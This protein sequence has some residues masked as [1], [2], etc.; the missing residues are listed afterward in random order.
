MAD[1]GVSQNAGV[2][3][4]GTGPFS[5]LARQQYAALAR[6]RW[7]SFV[8]GIRS[9]RGVL[10]LGA[11]GVA[12]TIYAS[13]GLGLGAAAGAAANVL[14]SRGAWQ[15][16]AIEFWVLCILWQAIS[17]ALASFQ[18]QY[19][20]SGLLRFPIS[21]SSFFLLHLIFGLL[22]VSTIIGGLCCLGILLGTA[23][24]RPDLL[25]WIAVVLAGFAAFNILLVRVI[26]AWIDRWLA[27]RRSREIVSAIFLLG[28]LSLQLLNPALRGDEDNGTGHHAAQS[29]AML[30]MERIVHG[31]M[32]ATDR[33]QTWLP[34]GLAATAMQQAD[35][36]A[37][38]SAIGSLGALG[39]YALCAGGL[40]AL[41]LRAEYRGESLGEAPKRKRV[42]AP[43]SI[44]FIGAGPIAAVYEKELSTLKRSMPQLYALI[45]PMLMVF[46]IGNVF[47]SGLSESGHSYELAFPVCV[48]YGLLGFT[49]LIYN[50]LGGEG[51]GIQLLLLSPTPMRT[52]LSGKNLFHASLF[53]L[54]AL[55]SALLASVRLGRP[56]VVVA[57]T[58]LGWLAFALPANLAAGNILSLTMPYRVN[59]GRIGRQAGSQANALLSML[60]QAMIL[61]IGAGVIGLCT[62]LGRP[63][64]AVAILAVLAVGAVIALMIVLRNSDAIAG[65]RRDG[66]LAQLAKAE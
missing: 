43:E 47:H 27:K 18:E 30:R 51:K 45:V 62:F 64:L 9:I 15:F 38:A 33:G 63:W 65:K 57:A 16:L 12:Y 42:A 32:Q 22:D 34:P 14:V 4:M 20:L 6:M 52:I 41:R 56:S 55:V 1:I 58:T 25:G 17:V 36:H 48:A 31:A 10:D 28:L 24:A 54:V 35:K 23:V 11:T 46:V 53:A 2:E 60:I 26:F 66:L 21:F 40:L 29:V 13:I 8:I 5:Q 37:E 61:G 7:Q 39:M 49:Q 50:S 59:L 3:T 19:D 44:W